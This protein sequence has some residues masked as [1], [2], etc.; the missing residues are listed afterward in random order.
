M[1][2]STKTY[3]GVINHLMCQQQER[4]NE[5][6][7]VVRRWRDVQDRVG[8]FNKKEKNYRGERPREDGV[9]EQRYA[10]RE[11]QRIVNSLVSCSSKECVAIMPS[12]TDAGCASSCIVIALVLT[13]AKTGT[14]IP[15]VVGTAAPP[16]TIFN[17]GRNSYS[18]QSN[19]ECWWLL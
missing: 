8:Q 18:C 3:G 12:H 9:G 5:G 15:S 6:C 2:L 1:T 14:L 17:C 16:S 10:G 19:P 13:G 11:Q 7:G 4:S